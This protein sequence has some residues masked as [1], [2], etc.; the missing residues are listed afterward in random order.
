MRSF[1]LEV[2]ADSV[3]SVL[4]AE[5]GGADRIELCGNIVIGGT[6]PDVN[7]YREIRARSG[8]RIH[9]LIRP[10]FG[11]F[12]Y[13]DCECAVMERDIR[14]FGELGAQGVVIGALDPDGGLAIPVLERLVR[15][16]GG[17]SV[18]L[19]RA[20]D[21][22]RDPFAAMEQAIALGIDTILTSGQQNACRQ[23]AALLGELQKRSDG[24]IRIMAGAGVDASVIPGLYRETGITAYHMTGKTELA[25]PM[26]YRNQEVSMGL[27]SLSEYTLFRTDAEKIREAR[28]ALRALI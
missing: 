1:L 20:F 15:A 10:R 4:A 21:M 11:D 18:T 14:M 19:H 25:S 17:M 8:I 3:E 23:G 5:E 6:T 12:C 9:A 2:C 7:L 26:R 16:A 13:T 24:R 27:P 22:C 28:A